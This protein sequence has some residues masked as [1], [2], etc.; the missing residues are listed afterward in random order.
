[1]ERHDAGRQELM[2][3]AELV[4]HIADDGGEKLAADDLEQ[5]LVVHHSS[6]ADTISIVPCRSRARISS[7]S[8]PRSL[9]PTNSSRRMPSG[10]ISSRSTL[11]SSRVGICMGLQSSEN[12]T[13]N[14][15]SAVIV[16]RHTPGI[17]STT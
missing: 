5:R 15:V 9:A 1:V 11:S 8:A 10:S 12:M 4:E 2:L 17:V 7:S 13:L 6:S 14:P 3:I 16:S